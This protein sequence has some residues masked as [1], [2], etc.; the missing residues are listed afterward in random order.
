MGCQGYILFHPLIPVSVLTKKVL[1]QTMAGMKT[2]AVLALDHCV[3]SSVTGIYDILTMADNL[4]KSADRCHQQVFHPVIVSVHGRPVTCF[5]GLELVPQAGIRDLPTPDLVYLPVVSGD[6]APLLSDAALITW[7]TS[8]TC[9]RTILT[10][11]CAGVFI[12]AQTRALDGRSATTHWNL[13]EEFRAKFPEVAL[14]PEKMLVDEGD[15]ITGGGVT[16]YMDLALYL[17]AR[18]GSRA[19]AARVSKTLLIDPARPSQAPYAG[20]NLN[21]VHGDTEIQILQDFMAARYAD[22]LTVPDLAARAGL[23]ERTLARRFKK[24][25]GETP[26]GYLQHLRLNIARTLLETTALPIEQITWETGYSDASAFRR[27]FKKKTGLSPKAYR[28]RFSLI[29]P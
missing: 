27:L 2:I 4:A 3:Q 17:I 5:N 9:G 13:A 18:F 26:L 23:G 20:L 15:M 21:R 19:L 8:L 22:P 10:A 25:T 14:I 28:R 29:V 12:L 1:Y 6:L 16:A 11:V 7:L 24:A